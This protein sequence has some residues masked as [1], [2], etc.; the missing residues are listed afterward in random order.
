MSY[1]LTYVAVPKKEEKRYKEYIADVMSK[2]DENVEVEEYCVKDITDEDKMK[3]IN[4]Y[5]SD[6]AIDK[7]KTI[8]DFN[9]IYEEYG[10]D[11]NFNRW[12]FVDG[13]WK[14]YSTS[15]PNG[16]WDSYDIG[17][18]WNNNLL[19]K[20]GNK[21]NVANKN[22]VQLSSEIIP[23]AIIKDGEWIERGQMKWFATVENEKK[24]EVWDEEFYK[25]W[26]TVPDN[27]LIVVLSCHT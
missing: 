4:W 21:V 15:N 1:F 24:K 8:D 17:G 19:T 6:G 25:I 26:D 16:K 18:R 3:V 23:F 11:W 2:Y 20:N 13:A 27:D 10:K 12:R 14:E 5:I 9:E 22:D 7:S